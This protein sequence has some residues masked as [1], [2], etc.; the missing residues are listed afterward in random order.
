MTPLPEPIAS[1]AATGARNAMLDERLG[2][3]ERD[4][5][6]GVGRWDAGMFRLFGFEP[7]EG[8]PTLEQEQ[9][10]IH[11]DDRCGAAYAAASMRTA[12]RH[13]SR[14]RV[15]LPDGRV[16][17]LH[18]QWE[19]TVSAEAVPQRAMGLVVDDT[20]A[21]RLGDAMSR[22]HAELKIAVDL[23]NIAI[24]RH[25]LKL[26][27]IFYNDLAFRVLG[28][29]R[30]SDGVPLEEV[31]ALIHPDDLPRVVAAASQLSEGHRPVDTEARY[32]RADGGWVH[33]LSRR[34]LRRNTQ[35]EAIEFVGVAMDV[36]DRAMAQA[37]LRSANERVSLAARSVGMGSW[38]WNIETGAAIWDT[39]MFRLRGIA[40]QEAAP[41]EEQRFAMTHPDDIE[42]VRSMM[43]QST[44]NPG[45]ASYEFRVCWPDGTVR[46]LASRS[47]LVI[48]A[49]GQKRRL[50]G[51]N[52]DVTEA[53]NLQLDLQE[54]EIARRES[55]AKSEFLSRMSH[56]LRTPL[57]AVLGFA[58]LLQLQTD[59]LSNDQRSKL[60]HIESAGEHLL[61]LINDMLDLSS[62]ESQHFRLCLQAVSLRDV[63][64]ETLP[65]VESMAR[66]QGV[67]LRHGVLAGTVH[68]DR[69]RVKQVLINLLSNGIKYSRAGDTVT[70]SCESTPTHVKLSVQDT[71]CG[72]SD[73]QLAHLFEPFN[74]LGMEAQGIEG[75]GIGLALVKALV[76]RMKGTIAVTSQPGIGSLFEVLL[77][78]WNAAPVAAPAAAPSDAATGLPPVASDLQRRGTLLYIEDNPINVLLLEQLIRS[79]SNITI[80]SAVTGMAGVA[81]ARQLQPDLILV[82]IQLPDIDGLEVLYRLRQQPE[83]AHTQCVAL[84]ANAMPQD[85]Q[86]ALAAGFCDYWTKPIEFVPFLAALHR[87]LPVSSN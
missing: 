73:A 28:I 55:Q 16:R 40:P 29:E 30:R 79:Q 8:V 19:V 67:T 59:S 45:S 17:R 27:R 62:L 78:R 47:T 4:L 41:S 32:K 6:S 44:D 49:D 81:R 48:D 37:D 36:S 74:R 31:R 26:N 43:R 53:M 33:V 11:V 35:G 13:E 85:I 5:S 51:V 72:M 38:E 69:V 10:R 25:D 70:V 56:E 83:T 34:V 65:L 14:Y 84:S 60:T 46:W 2:T 3:W 50:I 64:S 86:L 15:V 68:A 9:Q 82:D 76:A 18:S 21:Y 54:A 75:T 22:Q 61:S 1:T 20:E 57:N 52:W 71:G 66:A 12:G 24:W 39:D 58:Q 63:L 80:E 23:A 87:L 77:P 7:S 42:R